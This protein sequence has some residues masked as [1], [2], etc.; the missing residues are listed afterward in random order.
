M[1]RM[2]I[3]EGR[4]LVRQRDEIEEKADAALAANAD[5][6]RLRQMPGIGLIN[7]MTILAE[8]GDLR[9]NCISC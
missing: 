4:S 3:A 5:Y 9:R 8:A 2:V 7:A 1:F 6:Q